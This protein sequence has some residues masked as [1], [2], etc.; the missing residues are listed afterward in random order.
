MARISQ[1]IGNVGMDHPWNQEE[2]EC[3]FCG[4]KTTSGSFWFGEDVVV[5]CSNCLYNSEM[6][7]VLLGDGIYEIIDEMYVGETEAY[8][9]DNRVRQLIEGV[10]AGIEFEL[11]KALAWQLIRDQSKRRTLP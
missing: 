5:L 6:V 3:S 10:T 2:F 7:G 9:R 8:K 4:R 11:Y 1:H